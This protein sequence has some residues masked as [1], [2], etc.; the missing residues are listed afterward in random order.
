VLTHALLEALNSVLEGRI[1]PMSV[2][3]RG[4][5]SHSLRPATATQA[6]ASGTC[7]PSADVIDRRWRGTLTAPVPIVG[8]AFLQT[9][10]G[11]HW[12]K[13]PGIGLALPVEVSL[14]AYAGGR[15]EGAT[16]GAALA[17]GY[18]PG[19]PVPSMQLAGDPRVLVPTGFQMGRVT[20]LARTEAVAFLV[21]VLP[22]ESVTME[23]HRLWRVREQL[24]S[25]LPPDV[26]QLLTRRRTG[27]VASSSG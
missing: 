9:P 24:A 6:S 25:S 13:A 2:D 17:G 14:S 19:V 26:R 8:L 5:W 18:L 4:E 22:R 10:D 1:D 16:L 23:R 3:I 27:T 11:L 21:L 7:Q 12:I 15:P 20:C